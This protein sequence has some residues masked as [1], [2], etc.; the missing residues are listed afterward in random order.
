[1]QASTTATLRADPIP[2]PYFTISTTDATS[3]WVTVTVAEAS[4]TYVTSVDIAQT[5][6]AYPSSIASSARSSAL[7]R[8]QIGGITVGVVLTVLLVLT[9]CGCYTCRRSRSSQPPGP[10]QGY[11]RELRIPED[12]KTTDYP[13][14]RD[15]IPPTVLEKLPENVLARKNKHSDKLDFA[16]TRP[17]AHKRK[18][19]QPKRMDNL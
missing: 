17:T 9:L 3:R 1:M 15:P 16:F 19:E 13:E 11:D 4:Q 14:E 8:E 2:T 5:P 10:F 18:P 6:P 12:E 7:S